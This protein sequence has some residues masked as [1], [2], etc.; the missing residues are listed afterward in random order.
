MN[1]GLPAS[2]NNNSSMTRVM[3]REP[4]YGVSTLQ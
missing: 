3:G 1:I 2:K 4:T